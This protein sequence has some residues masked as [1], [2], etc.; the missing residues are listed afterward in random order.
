MIS[1][2]LFKLSYIDT[3]SGIMKYWNLIILPVNNC[4]V[5]TFPHGLLQ[6]TASGEQLSSSV[7]A[8]ALKGHSVSIGHLDGASVFSSVTVKIFSGFNKITGCVNW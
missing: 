2:L 1:Y 7:Q 8:S 6:H 4:F 5:Q 3:F